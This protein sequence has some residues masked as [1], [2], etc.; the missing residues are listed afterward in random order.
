MLS[1]EY[2][3]LG[4]SPDGIKECHC[5][6]D[7]LVEFTCPYTSRNMDPKMAFLLDTVG[8]AIDANGKHF[9][10]KNHI[11]YFQVQTGMS[12]CGLKQCDFVVFT[13]MGIFMAKTQ[14][15]L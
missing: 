14:L 7:R 11:H 8:G 2:G 10:R 1:P 6:R 13:N 5:C 9:L 3:W 4:A 15:I 12:V